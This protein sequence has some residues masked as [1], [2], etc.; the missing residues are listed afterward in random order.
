MHPTPL[1]VGLPIHLA[2]CLPKTQGSIPN[3]QGRAVNEPAAFEVEEQ[4]LLRRFALPIAIAAS[5][6]RRVSKYTPSTQK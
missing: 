2:E 4:V 1:L 3:G 6:F 5:R